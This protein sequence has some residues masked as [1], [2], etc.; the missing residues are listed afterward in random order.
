MCTRLSIVYLKEPNEPVAGNYRPHQSISDSMG[1]V[2]AVL[3][4]VDLLS[5]EWPACSYGF[6]FKLFMYIG[7]SITEVIYVFL[8]FAV[9]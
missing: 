9:Q 3:V 8:S 4:H 5:V 6:T 2:V 1:L 7:K